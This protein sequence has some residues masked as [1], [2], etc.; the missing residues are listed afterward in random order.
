VL[1]GEGGDELFAG[2]PKYAGRSLWRDFIS[3]FPAEVTQTWSAGF[4]TVRRRLK[5]A[6]EAL[7]VPE[8]AQRAA[9]WFASFSSREREA[10]LSRRMFLAQVRPGP[11]RASF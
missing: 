7:S 9:T 10:A 3:A 11:S 4:L 1:A 5:A 6:L 8:E 2:Y